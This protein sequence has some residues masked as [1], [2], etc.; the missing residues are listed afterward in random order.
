MK[1]REIEWKFQPPYASHFGGV[2]EREIRSIRNVLYALM[3]EQ[4]LKLTDERLNTLFCEIENILNSRPL[5]EASR[6]PDDLEPLTPNH[7]LL[8]NVGVTFPPGLFNEEDLYT[9]R[10]WKQ[11][12]YLADLFW[13]R[14]RKEYL[15]LLQIRQKWFTDRPSLNV[16]DLVLLTDQLLPRNQWSTGR[17]VEIKMGRGG[18]VRSAMVLV[19]KYKGMNKGIPIASTTI[20]EKPI[21]KL[22][23]L[24][25]ST[26]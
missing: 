12:Q 3:N 7:L 20:V 17:V 25:S 15:P 24:K 13:L 22:I 21:V 10:R 14:W 18:R 16:G 1:Q 23:L 4:R 6:S 11:V 19:A 2:W 9:N 5:T 26:I 8:M